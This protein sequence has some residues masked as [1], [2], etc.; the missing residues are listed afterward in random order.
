M[1]YPDFFPT[2]GQAFIAH[3]DYTEVCRNIP[4][5]DSQPSPKE[6][7]RKTCHH[8]RRLA[9]R[10]VYLPCIHRKK[11]YVLID[12]ILS[13][14]RQF[15]MEIVL[16][17]PKILSEQARLRL[18]VTG[19]KLVLFFYFYSHDNELFTIVFNYLSNLFSYVYYSFALW[20]I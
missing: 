17:S 20:I 2:A 11:L 13:F 7:F 16:F 6:T 3:S 5:I 10:I 15:S 18:P 14:L 9:P 12:K 19:C 4:L 8:K 1:T